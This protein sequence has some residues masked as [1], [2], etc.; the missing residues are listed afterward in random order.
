MP[1]KI[2]WNLYR[3]RSL[4]LRR[5]DQLVHESSLRTSIGL[6]GFTHIIGAAGAGKTLVAAAVAA[7]VSRSSRVEWI[8]T[9]SKTRFL[10]LLKATVN[11]LDGV[12][13]N[14]AVTLTKGHSNALDTVLSLPGSIHEDTS[15]VVVDPV[16]R[17]IDMARIDPILW[18]QELLEGV[19]PTLAALSED[20]TVDV[21]VVSEMRFIPDLGI[22]PVHS[23]AISKWSDN[24]V[25]VCLDGSGRTSSI[26][27]EH[28][29]EFRKIAQLRVL[30]S[31]ACQL[32]VSQSLEGAMQC[33]EKGF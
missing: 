12:E 4:I 16:T 1:N 32:S 26:F 18:G 15:L 2:L 14:I 8:N 20:G 23:D 10:P 7:D 9:D 22:R 3:R 25:K 33:L 21:I 5:D 29:N 6:S 30:D 19:L 24:T 13:E 11:H 27:K 17:V 31:G 28:D